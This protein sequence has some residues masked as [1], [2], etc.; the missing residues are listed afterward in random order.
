[1][2]ILLAAATEAEIAPTLAWLRSSGNEHAVRVCITGVGLLAASCRLTRI[3]AGAEDIDLVI[4]AGIAGSFNR[5]LQLGECVLVSNEQ[6]ADLGAEDGETFLD[7]F[8]M[9]LVPASDAPFSDRR[10]INP[11]ETCILPTAHLKAVSGLTV[12]TVSGYEP[13]IAQRI[14]RYGADTESMEG[15]ALHYACLS[16]DKP[17]LHLR[18]ISNYVTRRD[19]SAWKLSDSIGALNEQLLRWLPVALQAERL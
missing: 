14:A 15:A 1:M 8:D 18:A 2:N 5:D 17:F 4:G 13:T 16:M 11:M 19:R 3:I 7:A 10:L 9:G 12:L 6:L